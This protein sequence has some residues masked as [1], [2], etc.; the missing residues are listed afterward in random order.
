ML[1]T[2]NVLSVNGVVNGSN[3]LTVNGSSYLD[4]VMEVR[5]AGISDKELTFTNAFYQSKIEFSGRHIDSYLNSGAANPLFFKWFSGGD[6]PCGGKFIVNA[7]KS[8]ECDIYNSYGN[9]NVVFQRNGSTYMT[10]SQAS[11]RIEASRD[12]FLTTNQGFA[13]F[14]S[15]CF[16]NVLRIYDGSTIDNFKFDGTART[17]KVS[18]NGGGLQ[19][20]AVGSDI[21]IIGNINNFSS[22]DLIFQISGVEYMR[23]A[24]GS[25]DV[26]SPFDNTGLNVIGNI[27]DITVSDEKLKTIIEDI[28]IN[29]IDCVKNIKIKTFEYKDEKYSKI[30]HL[31]LLHRNWKRNCLMK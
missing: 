25:I 2:G 31:V 5:S 29:C 27:I 19:L 13:Y 28:D 7:G 16:E 30:I 21:Q 12:L 17:V 8:I 20:G 1:D 9:N 26:D 15:S 4:G 24:S 18:T 14:R 23:F 22:N 11:N 10:F 3:A 6:I